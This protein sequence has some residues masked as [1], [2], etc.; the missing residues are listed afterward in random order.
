MEY[1]I[2]I[3]FALVG[4]LLFYRNK[5][6]KAQVDAKLAK[7]KGRDAHLKIVQDEVRQAIDDLD[8]G[9][10]K[11]KEKRDSEKESNKNLSDKQRAD[12]WNNDD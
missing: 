12:R 3:I 7:T 1:I 8:Q 5:A 10:A 9:I 2:G 6:K 11:M 4:G